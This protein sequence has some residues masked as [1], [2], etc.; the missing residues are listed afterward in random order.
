M[1]WHTEFHPEFRV[2]EIHYCGI[3]TRAELADAITEAMALVRQHGTALILGNCLS[4][5]GG[6]S[7]TDLYFF[8]ESIASTEIA[9]SLKEAIIFPSIPDA[10][11]HVWFW[12]STCHN[13]GLMVRVF[14]DRRNAL[15]WLLRTDADADGSAS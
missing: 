7:T 3:L 12:E 1:P 5:E 9:A 11:D 2:I 4:L 6:H 14:R 13:H 8:A 10:S 15:E